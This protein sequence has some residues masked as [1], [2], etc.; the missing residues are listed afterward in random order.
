M[1]EQH[2]P[3]EIIKSII[4][5]ADT[6]I[7]ISDRILAAVSYV[8]IL[9]LISLLRKNSPFVQLHARQG[10]MV[11]AAWLLINLATPDIPIYSWFTIIIGNI[12]VALFSITGIFMSIM[13]QHWKMPY[14]IGSWVEK[15]KI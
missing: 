1:T 6:S 11:F 7:P 3:S 14:G 9:F 8:N 12:A 10:L 2:K 15:W 13:G 4:P 5:K